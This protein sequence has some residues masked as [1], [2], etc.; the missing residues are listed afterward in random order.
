MQMTT[1][2]TRAVRQP[3]DAALLARSIV[4]PTSFGGIYERHSTAIFRFVAI[5]VGREAAEDI[6]AETFTTAFD[7]RSRFDLDV[8]SARPWLYGIAANQLK[9][10]ADAERRWLERAAAGAIDVDRFEDLGA[11]ARVDAERMAPRL[12]SALLALS[13]SERDAVVL[14]TLEDLTMEQLAQALGIR[15]GAAKV[16]LSRGRA[17]LRALLDDRPDDEADA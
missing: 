11:D 16:R 10:H 8:A 7:R 5:R 9:K 2:T 6:V 3:T 13:R 1:E 4:E 15:V 17:R 14:A 12:A